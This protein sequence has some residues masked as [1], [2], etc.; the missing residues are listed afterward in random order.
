MPVADVFI[1]YKSEST[2]DL[3]KN[4]ICPAIEAADFTCWYAKRDSK[5]GAYGGNIKRAIEQC[6]IFLLV[7]DQAALHSAHIKSETALA[8]R[9][10][11]SH[12]P[13]TLLPFRVDHCN[14]RD[15]DDLDYYLICQQIVDGC[16]P[17]AQHIQDLIDRI[18]EIMLA[19]S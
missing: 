11:D 7:L 3:V 5:H 17:D 2:L 16:P 1:S 6:R 8:F 18:S 15:D 14:L 19:S 13:I 12:E 9:R 10:F 4:A